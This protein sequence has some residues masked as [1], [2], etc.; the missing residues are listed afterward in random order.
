[1]RSWLLVL[2]SILALLALGCPGEE[3]DDDDSSATDDDD[4]VADDDDTAGDDDVVYTP[5]PDLA[6]FFEWDP[7]D[8]DAAIADGTTCLYFT[9][10]DFGYSLVDLMDSLVAEYGNETCPEITQSGPP[11]EVLTTVMG[12]CD[13]NGWAFDGSY[14]MT[15]T[16]AGSFH[17]Y[18][19]DADQFYV[20]P[21]DNGHVAGEVQ[22]DEYFFHGRMEWSYTFD[23][24]FGT[25]GVGLGGLDTD[26][27]ETDVEQEGFEAYYA[28]G[29]AP[30]DPSWSHVY[31]KGWSEAVLNAQQQVEYSHDFYISSE[32]FWTFTSVGITV[33]SDVN[34]CSAEPLSGGLSITGA[35]WSILFAP[36]GETMCN[37]Q[38]PIYGGTYLIGYF[39][40]DIW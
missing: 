2:M 23:D 35:P 12:G 9:L 11:D 33:I 37:G 6:P 28:D 7:Y 32:G 17:I 30:G 36:D 18:T 10:P 16:D 4:D 20:R 39:S 14:T 15:D 13:T 38:V 22:S 27:P 31:Y 21:V 24:V 8:L 29:S 19:Y 1:M 40:E 5:P 34:Q 25:F 3:G 26:D